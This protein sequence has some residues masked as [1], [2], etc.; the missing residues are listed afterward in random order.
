MSYPAPYKSV[1]SYSYMLHN[2]HSLYYISRE[3]VLDEWRWRCNSLSLSLFFSISF[4]LALILYFRLCGIH[5][6]TYFTDD[7]K[8]NV[9]ILYDGMRR[10]A[11]QA[12]FLALNLLWRKHSTNRN[13]RAASCLIWPKT[14]LCG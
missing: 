13:D 5:M 6:H 14:E 9:Q 8:L 7:I 4:W 2:S 11:C 1:N 10:D 3:I 12:Q